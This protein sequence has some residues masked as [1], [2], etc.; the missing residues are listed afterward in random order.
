MFADNE[1]KEGFK[2]QIFPY[3]QSTWNNTTLGGCK[4]RYVHGDL[5][6]VIFSFFPLINKSDFM[7]MTELQCNMWKS[8]RSA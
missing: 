4:Y 7:R 2:G 6:G 1:L 8:S 5:S 3:I